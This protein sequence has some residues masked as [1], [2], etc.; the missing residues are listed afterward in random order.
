M[1]KKKVLKEYSK[2]FE[3]YFPY[4]DPEMHTF[5]GR[6]VTVIGE[7]DESD[8]VTI[9][10]DGGEYLWDERWFESEK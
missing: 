10:E 7:A 5:F 3:D 6:E 2:S 9:A 8:C 1:R 4:T